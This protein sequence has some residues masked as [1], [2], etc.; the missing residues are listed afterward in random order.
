MTKRYLLFLLFIFPRC[1]PLPPTP[2][3][4]A[5]DFYMRNFYVAVDETSIRRDD[6]TV[7]TDQAHGSPHRLEDYSGV[8]SGTGTILIHENTVPITFKNLRLSKPPQE[9]AFI[10]I[11]GVVKGKNPEPPE[12]KQI[13]YNLNGFEIRIVISSIEVRVESATAAVTVARHD[14]IYYT[15]TTNSL[16]LQSQLC[17]IE[18]NGAIEATNFRGSPSFIAL[19]AT[20]R[21]L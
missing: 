12:P 6:T 21:L 5:P 9:T 20:R 15:T 19:S 2:Q 11:S 7:P 3:E 1:R 14:P 18:P 8:S 10:A 16:L 4:T 17:S 13:V